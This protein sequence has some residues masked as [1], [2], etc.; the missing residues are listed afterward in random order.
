VEEKV[1]EATRQA[2]KM[3]EQR[4]LL[5]KD[6][7]AFDSTCRASMSDLSKRRV[8]VE[9]EESRVSGWVLPSARTL[10]R[11]CDPRARSPQSYTLRAE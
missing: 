6:R 10:L 4:A 1:V 5:S 9:A 3:S 8:E 7:D 2:A 11:L